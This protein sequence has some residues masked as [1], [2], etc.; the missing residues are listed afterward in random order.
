MAKFIWFSFFFF[1]ILFILI[2]LFYCIWEIFVIG[3]NQLWNSSC[4]SRNKL[5]ILLSILRVSFYFISECKW[6][7]IFKIFLIFIFFLIVIFLFFFLGQIWFIPLFLISYWLRMSFNKWRMKWGNCYC[8]L[9]R[10]RLRNHF[11]KIF[12]LH[13]RFTTIFLWSFLI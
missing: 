10:R 3:R 1:I 2:Y 5:N 11:W 9:L 12:I 6:Y 8:M 13:L 4:N 7:L